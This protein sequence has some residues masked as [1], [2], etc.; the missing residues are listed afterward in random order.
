MLAL[1]LEGRRV[2][3]CFQIFSELVELLPPRFVVEPHEETELK[4]F[5]LI[6]TTFLVGERP[7]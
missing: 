4:D 7:L 5:G 2:S 3:G 1:R 6:S